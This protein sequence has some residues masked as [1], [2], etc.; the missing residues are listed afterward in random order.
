MSQPQR[1]LLNRIR[2]NRANWNKF[3]EIA[4]Y[5]GITTEEFLDKVV[6]IAVQKYQIVVTIKEPENEVVEQAPQSLEET[7]QTMP[8]SQP[9][10]DGFADPEIELSKIK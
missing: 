3:K 9:I 7:F 6:S 8:K 10:D 2:I 4:K 5:M 1:V